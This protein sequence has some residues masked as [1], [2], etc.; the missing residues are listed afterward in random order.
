MAVITY[1]WNC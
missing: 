1:L